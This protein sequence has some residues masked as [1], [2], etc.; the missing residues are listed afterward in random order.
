MLIDASGRVLGSPPEINGMIEAEA[1]QYLDRLGV[2]PE[3]ITA[4]RLGVDFEL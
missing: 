2:R 4:R 3:N 1:L